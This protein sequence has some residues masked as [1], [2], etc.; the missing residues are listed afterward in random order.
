MVT[1]NLEDLKSFKVHVENA[2]K[3]LSVYPFSHTDLWKAK[4]HFSKDDAKYVARQTCEFFAK[5]NAKLEGDIKAMEQ[6]DVKAAEVVTEDKSKKAR[7][8]RKP[9]GSGAE[10]Q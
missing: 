10:A 6:S 9:Q 7:T 2:A 1:P 4:K 3:L 5:F 8:R